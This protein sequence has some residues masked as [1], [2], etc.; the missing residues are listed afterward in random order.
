MFAGRTITS[1]YVHK[2]NMKEDSAPALIPAVSILLFH[3]S[4]QEASNP[5]DPLLS[6]SSDDC[7]ICKLSSYVLYIESMSFPAS[8]DSSHSTMISFAFLSIVTLGTVRF[9]PIRMPPYK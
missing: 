7:D 3:W 4:F 5:E 8:F 6:H 1:S 9:A 2:T